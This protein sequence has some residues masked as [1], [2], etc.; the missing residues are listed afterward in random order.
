MAGANRTRATERLR[1]VSSQ[2]SQTDV[3]LSFA[4]F[5]ANDPRYLALELLVRVIDDG[6]STRLHRRICE[7]LGLA[8]EVF[9]TLEPYEEAGVLDLGGAIE[10]SKAPLFVRS[11]LTLLAEL[12]ERPVGKL[13]L[14]KVKRRYMWQL[15]ASLDDAQALCAHYGQRALLGQDG[16]IGA[17]RE[18]IA[19]VTAAELR[20]VAREVLCRERLHV[21]T[22]GM[23]DRAQRKAVRRAMAKLPSRSVR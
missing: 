16:H 21:V 10:H 11:A 8:Y 22:V 2:G 5:G 13:E 20:S 4:T 7:E 17:L 15:E 6:M 19:S 18:Q 23:L 3:R 12:C 14:D 1:C 9:A